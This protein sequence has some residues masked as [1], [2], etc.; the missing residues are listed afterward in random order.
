MRVE[1]AGRGRAGSAPRRA[2][3]LHLS[4]RAGSADQLRAA[5][6][7]R[8]CHGDGCSTGSS[9]RPRPLPTTAS[10]SCRPRRQLGW[11]CSDWTNACAN[12]TAW[13]IL[14][15]APGHGTVLRV[16]MPVPAAVAQEAVLAVLLADDQGIVRR[17]M[18][19]LLESE[20]GM[21]IVAEAS[22]GQEALRL[23]ESPAPDVVI[24]D[25][26]HAEAQWHRRGGPGAEASTGLPGH[27][28]EHVRR[29]IVRGPGAERG[30]ARRTCSRRRPMT[31]CCRRCGPSLRA[32]PS[33]APR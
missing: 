23:C 10:G 19:A 30:R 4:G 3:H 28:P 12:C 20:P 11:G 25:V 31:I 5:R 2:P 17:G 6:A 29:R 14:Q 13:M 16:T 21:E 15:S 22:D 32:S 9:A 1:S 8:T 7:R 18:R 33:S 27:R 26:A 24:L